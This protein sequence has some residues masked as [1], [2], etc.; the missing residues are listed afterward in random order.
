MSGTSDTDAYDVRQYF[1][2]NNHG[3]VVIT[4]RLARL[5]QLGDAQR[6]EKVSLDQARA[7]LKSRYKLEYGK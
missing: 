7:I 3:S 2:A 1:P 4:T 5:E 6:L